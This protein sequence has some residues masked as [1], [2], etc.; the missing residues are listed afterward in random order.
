MPAYTHDSLTGGSS[1]LDF[2]PCGREC[3]RFRHR[4]CS[5][6]EHT[7]E[8]SGCEAEVLGFGLGVAG[9]DHGRFTEVG[10]KQGGR[11]SG[12]A[13]RLYD[14]HGVVEAVKGRSG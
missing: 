13:V 8:V 11:E 9:G 4:T 12:A 10:R 5:A 14:G 3:A 1:T 6:R 7:G 2:S